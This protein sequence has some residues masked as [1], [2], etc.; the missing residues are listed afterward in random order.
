ME[1]VHQFGGV[2]LVHPG[3]VL[4]CRKK[5]ILVLQI[6]Y[7]MKHLLYVSLFL[8]ASCSSIKVTYDYDSQADFSKYKTYEF[9]DDAKNFPIQELDRAR[10]LAAIEK[11]MAAK[12]FTKSATPD[13]LLDLQVKLEQKQTATATNTGGYYGP[14]RYGWGAGYGGTTHINVE[15]YVDGTLFVNMIDKSTEKMVW[16]GR[17]TKTLEEHPSPQKKEQN[18]NYAVQQIFSKYPP[19]KK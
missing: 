15:N 17:G 12:G 4:H 9:T 7:A 19:K 18:I 13:V 10:V 6:Q 5:H 8:L 3:S 16:Q 14:Y 1:L 2:L 11:E